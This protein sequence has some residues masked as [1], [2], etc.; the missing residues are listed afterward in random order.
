MNY[1]YVIQIHRTVKKLAAA[2]LI[3]LSTSITLAQT[4]SVLTGADVYS[5]SELPFSNSDLDQKFVPAPFI[6]MRYEQSIGKSVGMSLGLEASRYQILKPSSVYSWVTG[7]FGGIA[8][9]GRDTI[10]DKMY[11]V[12]TTRIPLTVSAKIPLNKKQ[13]LSI[14][15]VLGCALQR[16]VFQAPMDPDPELFG[17]P[18]D[19]NFKTIDCLVS[20]GVELR[21]FVCE[22][23]AFGFG[24]NVFANLA[25]N[26]LFMVYY[27]EQKRMPDGSSVNISAS[28]SFKKHQYKCVGERMTIF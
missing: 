25:N 26:D 9:A 23:L 22:K 15:P 13:T 5:R 20:T 28:W 16:N 21:Y 11:K 4:V 12:Q 7:C 6:G 2:A 14:A 10:P 1:I 17:F 24:A 8:S 3:L 18:Q 27:S 19:P